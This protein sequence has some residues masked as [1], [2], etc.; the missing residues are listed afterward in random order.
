MLDEPVID[1]IQ[2]KLKTRSYIKGSKI[3]YMGGLVDKIVF[4]IRGKMT[5]T[6]E[7]GSKSILSEGDFCGEE[8]LTWCL[9]H[10]S[11]TKGVTE[12]SLRLWH[13]EAAVFSRCI[14][15]SFHTLRITYNVIHYNDVIFSMLFFVLFRWNRY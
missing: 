15:Y 13:K 4:I 14:F 5:S 3:L 6:G 10:S 9:E 7:D 1:A 8:L 11:L 12:I 2:E